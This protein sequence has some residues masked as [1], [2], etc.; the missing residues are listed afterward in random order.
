M[1]A[2][3]VDEVA[4]GQLLPLNQAF[5]T[6]GDIMYNVLGLQEEFNNTL[7]DR[8]L[9]LILLMD[10]T[11][12]FNYISRSWAWRVWAKMQWSHSFHCSP[13]GGTNRRLNLRK[14]RRR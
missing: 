5:V 3:V 12:G 1:L 10:C 11:K 2:L 4:A 7:T 6:G 14:P 8:Q 9:R 13:T